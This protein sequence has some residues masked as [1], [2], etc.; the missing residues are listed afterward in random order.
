MAVL[1]FSI[2]HRT[3]NGVP[4]NFAAA[5]GLMRYLTSIFFSIPCYNFDFI[6]GLFG[7]FPPDFLFFFFRSSL[8]FPI[9]GCDDC[10]S[11]PHPSKHSQSLFSLAL[12]H[13][14]FGHSTIFIQSSSSLLTHNP[15]FLFILFSP[16][17]RGTDSVLP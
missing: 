12:L 1:M 7:T 6:L 2:C 14:L 3:S 9:I 16:Q 8:S 5:A 15:L 13:F 10:L 17:S 11:L 4:K